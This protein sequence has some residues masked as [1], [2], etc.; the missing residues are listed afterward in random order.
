MQ[1]KRGRNRE[2]DGKVYYRWTIQIPPEEIER[3]GWRDK[4]PLDFSVRAG[5][6]SVRK[7]KPRG[8]SQ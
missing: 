1:L 3:L 6:L 7:S 4:E 5:V 2:V 8:K